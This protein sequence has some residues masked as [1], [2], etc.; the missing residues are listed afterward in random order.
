VYYVQ[1]AH[2]RISTMLGKLPKERS[3]SAL[4]GEWGSD[5]LHDAERAL[6]Q[7]VVAFADEVLE[8]AAR[9]A[10]HRIAS[11]ALELARDFTTFYENCRVIGASPAEVESFRIALS[12][13]AQSVIALSLGLLGVSSPE[14]M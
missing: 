13:A 8:A 10:P 4:A 7:R 2:A 9:R 6:I 12:T 11:Y 3:A 14:Q 5:E 1:Y